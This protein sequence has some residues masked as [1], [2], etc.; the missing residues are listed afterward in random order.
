MKVRA[1]VTV[2]ICERADT[3]KVTRTVVARRLGT[4]PPRLNVLVRGRI[5]KFTCEALRELRHARGYR[6][7]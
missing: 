6:S 3:W 5:D 1:D 7:G 2:A 4:A